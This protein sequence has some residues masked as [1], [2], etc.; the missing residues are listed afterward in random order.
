MFLNFFKCSYATI[1]NLFLNNSFLWSS[2]LDN[3]NATVPLVEIACMFVNSQ[4]MDWGGNS[5][6][7]GQGCYMLQEAVTVE[8]GSMVG[9]WRTDKEQKKVEKN[10]LQSHLMYPTSD[11]KSVK[12]EPE[13]PEW[14]ATVD[15]ILQS[16]DLICQYCFLSLDP[17]F[18]KKK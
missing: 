16:C 11:V 9:W 3:K 4:F 8:H 18:K 2:Y 10:L 12:I 15:F 1:A 13:A 5:F 6:L 14:E 7:L 17:S